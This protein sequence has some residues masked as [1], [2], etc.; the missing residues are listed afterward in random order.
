MP[1]DTP[2]GGTHDPALLERITAGDDTAL[3]R[4]YDTYSAML[5]GLA[6][7]LTGDRDEAEDIVSAVFRSVWQ[8]P[9]GSREVGASMRAWLVTLCRRIAQQRPRLPRL[10]P[11]ANGRV[12]MA[13]GDTAEFSLAFSSSADAAR[14]DRV[15]AALDVLSSTE[16]E[17]LDL[18]FMDGLSIEDVA[19]RLA[20]PSHG[21]S[22]LVHS[23]MNQLRQLLQPVVAR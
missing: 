18:V 7:R 22:M 11:A 14:R 20:L 17:A 15:L 4:L 6:L 2:P 5:F 13:Q 23:A 3:G 16:R 8:E 9:Q 19:Q 12:G 1:E 21:A 10:V